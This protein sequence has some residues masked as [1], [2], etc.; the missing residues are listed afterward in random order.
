MESESAPT[1]ICVLCE[2]GI[3]HQGIL[4]CIKSI[5][6]SCS[7]IDNIPGK[8]RIVETIGVGLIEVY[9]SG[10]NVDV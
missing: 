9:R 5:V 1:I 2:L 7:T 8:A 10:A 6:M 3:W 4:Q